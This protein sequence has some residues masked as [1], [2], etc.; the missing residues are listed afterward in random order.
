MELSA[1]RSMPVDAT[2]AKL[3]QRAF[4]S[5]LEMRISLQ[6]ALEAANALPCGDLFG[7]M[8]ATDS[9]GCCEIAQQ[10][11]RMLLSDLHDLINTDHVDCPIAPDW[12]TLFETQVK[13][14]KSWIPVVNKWH[15]RL[16]FGSE[17]A[18]SKMKVFN[19]TIFDGID[20]ALEDKHRV[21]EKSRLL[22][23]ESKRPGKTESEAH[24]VIRRRLNDDAA[25]VSDDDEDAR[26]ILYDP[27]VYD[28]RQLYSL[29][30]KVPCT[31]IRQF[32]S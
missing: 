17:L 15:A 7:S 18:K 29:L 3:Q 23:V 12:Q 6:R 8:H 25:A 4:E 31:S 9:S 28:D 14:K 1:S 16:N 21:I 2:A 5:S 13:L 24:A 22:F 10:D 32:S 27:E 19:Q 11:L 30:L 20:L 26:A